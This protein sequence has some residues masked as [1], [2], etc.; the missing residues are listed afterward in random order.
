M[1]KRKQPA[2]ERVVAFIRDAISKGTWPTGQRI[3][4]IS[5]LCVATNCADKPVRKA[6]KQ[7]ISQGILTPKRCVSANDKRP[8]S[9]PSPLET[10]RWQKL[11]TRLESDI[12]A[13]TYGPGNTLP[14]VA[15][16]KEEYGVHY[17]TLKKALDSLVENSVLTVYKRSYRVTQ[18]TKRTRTGFSSSIVAFGPGDNSGISIFGEQ[19]QAFIRSVDRECILRNVHPEIVGFQESGA[20]IKLIDVEKMPVKIN[21]LL[22]NASVL[23]FVVWFGGQ[24]PPFAFMREF[25]LMLCRANKPIAVLHDSA[26][27]KLISFISKNRLVQFF[28]LAT[29]RRCAVTAGKYLLQ[30]Q[31]RHIA[32]IS[33]HHKSIWSQERLAGLREA[34]AS[35]G[36][37]ARGLSS[38]PVN[39]LASLLAG[40][41]ANLPGHRLADT[42]R[43]RLPSLPPLS[44]TIR[45]ATAVRCR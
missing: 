7:L 31:H 6:I 39:L 28:S 1:Q 14:A 37:P 3:P 21:K 24:P 42:V 27:N 16:L 12:A 23:G 13:G 45:R 5:W 35:A 32:Y 2:V 4:N 40:K 26:D 44:S 36:L 20:G 34:Y 41:H 17:Q 43:Y 9:E 38:C 33:G 29:G 22:K 19:A 18:F 8:V 11:K 15:Q 10:L 30:L 25:L